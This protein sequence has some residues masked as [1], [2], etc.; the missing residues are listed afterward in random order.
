MN[1]HYGLGILKGAQMIRKS[2][3]SFRVKNHQLLRHASAYDDPIS[4]YI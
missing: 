1:F 3:F 4:E 2:V